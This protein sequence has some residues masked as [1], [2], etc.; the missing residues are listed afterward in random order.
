[1][2]RVLVADHEPIISYGIR[3]L[4]ESSN[5]I[6][7]V[8]SVNTKKQLI[9]YLKKGSIDVVLL[10]LDF[11]DS[12][13]MTMIRIIK[14]EFVTVRVLIF[15]SHDEDVY[16]APSVRAGASGFLLKTSPTNAIKRLSLIHI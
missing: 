10:S 4:F 5:D 1:M 3:I 13:G 11:A 7:I 8:N 12:N 6:K 2:I 9:D 15:S 14:K 16:A